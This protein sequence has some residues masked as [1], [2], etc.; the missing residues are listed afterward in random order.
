MKNLKE[1]YSKLA[2]QFSLPSYE[3]LDKDFELLYSRELFEISRPLVFIRR[4]ICDKIGWTCGMLQGLIQPN[5]GSMLSIEE[6]SF[7][8]KEEKQ[9]SFVKILKDLMYYTRKSLDLDLESTNEE[10]AEFIKE[11]YNKWIEIKPKIKKI[12]QQLKEGWKNEK[13]TNKQTNNHLG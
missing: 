2:N 1:N 13:E 5:P 6:S 4:R 11:L 12:S 10:E 3:E 8:S 7:F 9:D